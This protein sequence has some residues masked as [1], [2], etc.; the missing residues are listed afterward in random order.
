MV[1]FLHGGMVYTLNP[2][3]YHA[4]WDQLDSLLN[5][6]AESKVRR[7]KEGARHYGLIMLWGL[8]L[9]LNPHAHDKLEL[10]YE[11]AACSGQQHGKA[12]MNCHL[13]L[14]LYIS[15]EGHWSFRHRDLCCC[16]CSAGGLPKPAM[17]AYQVLLQ[18][19]S[20]P[21]SGSSMRVGKAPLKGNQLAAA[22]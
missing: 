4:S 19:L 8:D 21:P 3:S 6:P 5:E 11:V 1:L 12:A 17:H 20:W 18:I 22:A 10:L 9:S 13:T 14:R 15:V 7:P 2:Y 16:C